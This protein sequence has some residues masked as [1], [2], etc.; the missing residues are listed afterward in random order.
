MRRAE[1]RPYYFKNKKSR[2]AIEV[3]FAHIPGRWFS[4]GTKD[5][6][7]AVLFAEARLHD[8]GLEKPESIPT[9]RGYCRDFYM[10][11]DSGS[12]RDRDRKFKKAR[13]PKYYEK[14]QAM[15]DNHILPRFG[16]ILVTAISE[17]AIE[18]WLPT[19]KRATDG[20]N[21]SDNTKNKILGVFRDV[22]DA[23]RRDGYRSD[24]PAR[25][26]ESITAESEER[27]PVPP[28]QTAVLFPSDPE[29]RIRIW[30]SDMWACYFSIFYDTGMRPGEIAALRVCDIYLTPSGYAVA[31]K[32]TANNDLR[33][34]VERVKTAGKG[35]SERLG[36]IYD[37]TAEL[38]LGYIKKHKLSGDSYLFHGPRG[39]FP[40]RCETANKHFKSILKEHGFFEEGMVQYCLRHT[41]ETERRG[42]MPDD[43]LAISMGHTKLRADYDH[44]KPEDLIRSIDGRRDSFFAS[45]RR[46]DCED[47]IISIDKLGTLES[48]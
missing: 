37:D 45:R 32:R 42:D 36:L 29:E 15:L 39:A 6:A 43:I 46:R 5:M 14:A 20:K 26:V 38:L 41:Y 25:E 13:A 34:I 35:Y 22:M 30:H 17:K 2:P 27:Q 40:L 24:N 10:K 44:R 28:D 21:A 8:D 19:I 4:T 3:R 9:L 48:H 12:F 23:V 11:E 1:N 18:E 16:D 7:E 31:T 47:D 33:R